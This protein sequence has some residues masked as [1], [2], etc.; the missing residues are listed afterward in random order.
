M[1]TEGAKLSGA[2]KKQEPCTDTTL[3]SPLNGRRRCKDVRIHHPYLSGQWTEQNNNDSTAIRAADKPE[4]QI[5]I[6]RL[7]IYLGNFENERGNHHVGNI[8]CN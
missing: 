7:F 4:Y 8:E 1:P 3:E 2:Y 5:I 6:L